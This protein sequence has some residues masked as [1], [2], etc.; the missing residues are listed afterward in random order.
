MKILM[1]LTSRHRVIVGVCYTGQGDSVL[2]LPIQFCAFVAQRT[3]L[4]LAAGCGRCA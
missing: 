3:E 4:E 2:P 1:V